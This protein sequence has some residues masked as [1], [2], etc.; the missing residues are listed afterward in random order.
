MEFLKK[1][2]EKVVLSVVLA[3]LALAVALLP[4]QIQRERQK[5]D[6][7]RN[8][9]TGNPKKYQPLNLSEYDTVLRQMT[10][11]PTLNFAGGHNLFNPVL[12]QI[13]PDGSRIK[14]VTGK[15]VGPQAVVVT[16]ITPLNYT[17][18]LERVAGNSYMFGITREAATR[19]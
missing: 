13:A 7:L 15:E 8:E 10:N 18:S 6:D 5:L 14:V 17:I 1:H 16:A 2:Y 4:V 3:G 9:I 12:W 19:P 11:P